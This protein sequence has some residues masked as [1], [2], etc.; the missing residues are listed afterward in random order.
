MVDFPDAAARIARLCFSLTGG[1]LLSYRTNPNDAY[2][3]V[4]VPAVNT[5][6]TTEPDGSSTFRAPAADIDEFGT[7][8]KFVPSGP[9]VCNFA[10]VPEKVP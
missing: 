10:V 5:P 9:N 2:M 6:L 7:S 4:G 1:I 8:M 3:A